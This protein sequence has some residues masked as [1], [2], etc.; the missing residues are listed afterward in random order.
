MSARGEFYEDDEPIE[1]LLAAFDLGI[2][3][4]TVVPPI[5]LLALQTQ[6]SYYS[7]TTTFSI[8]TTTTADSYRHL[9]FVRQPN[10]IPT[11]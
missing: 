7:L 5:A 6:G 4:V 8:G 3:G 11:A 9:N 1:D 10:V 2:K